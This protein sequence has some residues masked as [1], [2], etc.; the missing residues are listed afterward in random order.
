MRGE[1][2]VFDLKNEMNERQSSEDPFLIGIVGTHCSLKSKLTSA[3]LRAMASHAEY[4]H[5]AY[6][7]CSVQDK[8]GKSFGDIFRESVTCNEPSEALLEQ[9]VI[10]QQQEYDAAG[11][12]NK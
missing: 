7:F 11:V 8:D 3:I 1:L 12:T 10:K 4:Y 5:R 2:E 9:I 6:L